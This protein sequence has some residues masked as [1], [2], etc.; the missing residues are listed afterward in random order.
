MS[1]PALKKL[2]SKPG[3]HADGGNLYL[4]VSPDSSAKR[5]VFLYRWRGKTVEMGLGPFDDVGLAAAREKARGA[6]ELLAAGKSPLAAKRDQSARPTFGKVADDLIEALRP[7][8]KNAKHGAQWVMTLQVYAK[9]LRPLMVDEIETEDVLR[10]LRP[11]WN[12]KPETASRTRMRI[13]RV[14]DAARASGYRA[15]ENPARW[16]G[17]LQALLAPRAKLSR[18]HHAAMPY[19][20]VPAFMQKLRQNL[21]ISNL[22][23]EFGILTAAR[24]GETR[25]TSWSEIDRLGA[26][27]TLPP[28]RMKEAR[29]HVVPLADRALEILDLA[30]R[31]AGKRQS[32]LVFPGQ[33]LGTQL[34]DASLAAALRRAGGGAFTPHGFRS[35][36]RDWAGDETEFA[37]ETAEAALSHLVG[38]DSE[39]AYRRGTALAKRRELMKAWELFLNR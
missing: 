35:S 23:L 39:R 24:S 12:D 29:E 16:K 14:L 5:W 15:G 10:V 36:F 4:S 20:A 6:R 32:E 33:K 26:I 13:E 17:H 11:I 8:W 38:D 27:W 21:S 34:S 28:E 37:R 22:A 9:S 1:Q 7:S 18:G 19:A 2:A 3:R 31:I 25:G 30:K